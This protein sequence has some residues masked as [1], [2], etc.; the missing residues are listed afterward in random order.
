MYKVTYVQFTALHKKAVHNF[1]SICHASVLFL[2]S[3]PSFLSLSLCLCLSVS[4]SPPPPPSLSL[5]LSLP[6]PP[7]LCLCGSFSTSSCTVV[8]ADSITVSYLCLPLWLLT[9][10]LEFIHLLIGMLTFYGLKNVSCFDTNY[11]HGG[12]NSGW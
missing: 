11:H 6:P 4:L 2:P 1:T 10:S 9:H 5:Q 8:Y 3:L 7:S 12:Q